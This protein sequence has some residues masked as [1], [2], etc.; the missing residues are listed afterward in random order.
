MKNSG[1]RVKK[2]FAGR[3]YHPAKRPVNKRYQDNLPGIL[4]FQL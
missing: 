2:R 4:F 1:N 3:R